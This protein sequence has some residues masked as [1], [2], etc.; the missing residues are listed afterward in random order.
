MYQHEIVKKLLPLGSMC[1]QYPPSIYRFPIGSH[2]WR[3]IAKVSINMNSNF[4]LLEA[5]YEVLN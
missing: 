2:N 3:G 1:P 4:K 5:Y